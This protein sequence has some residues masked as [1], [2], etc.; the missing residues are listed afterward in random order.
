MV[1]VVAA[2]WLVAVLASVIIGVQNDESVPPTNFTGSTLLLH[3]SSA[4]PEALQN[5]SNTVNTV[6]ANT[7][8]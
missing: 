7:P 2:S 5:L 6:T 8:F 4:L 1:V 3:L